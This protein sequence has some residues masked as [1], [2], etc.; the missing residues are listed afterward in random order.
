MKL[1][2]DRAFSTSALE[3][4]GGGID[5]CPNGGLLGAFST[6]LSATSSFDAKLL[7]LIQGFSLAMEY[8]SHIWIE[9]DSAAFVSTLSSGQFDDANFKHSM[10]MLRS[11]TSQREV[12]FSTSIEKEIALMVTLQEEGPTIYPIL[13]LI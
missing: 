6:P 9:I 5:H 12:R 1:N 2:T 3:V 7:A 13:L 11:M 4:G 8:A 10:V